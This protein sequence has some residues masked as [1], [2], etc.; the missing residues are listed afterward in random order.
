MPPAVAKAEYNEGAI[1]SFM[2][3]SCSPNSLTGASGP[4]TFCAL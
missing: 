4:F 2:N 1:T 3:D